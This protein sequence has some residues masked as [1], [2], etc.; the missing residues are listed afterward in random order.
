[1]AAGDDTTISFGICF[2]RDAIYAASIRKEGCGIVNNDFETAF[3]FLCLEWVRKVLEKKGLAA[4]ALDRFMNLYR[5]GVTIPMINNIPGR[6]LI[7][8][9]LS[10]RQGDRTS[11]YW[12]CYGID[13]LLAYL[14]KRL[15]GILIHTLPVAGPAQH[16]HPCPLPPIEQRYK[17]QGYL[18]DCKPAITSMAEI[19]LV[20]RAC[21]LFEMASGCII[22]SK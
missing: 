7:N 6:R 2:S 5:D 14:N 16:G 18:D 8:K 15:Q 11:G 21:R 3:D 10:L 9:R 17:V 19:E 22:H 20:D 1:M 13:P 12:F 4:K